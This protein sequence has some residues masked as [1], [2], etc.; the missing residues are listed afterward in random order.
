MSDNIFL[1]LMNVPILILLLVLQLITPKITRKEIYFGVRIPEE[2]LDSDKLKK[3][4]PGFISANLKVCIPY[5]LIFNVILFFKSQQAVAIF[6]AGILLYTLVNTL[7]YYYYHREVIKIKHSNHWDE[8]KKQIV[9]VDTEFSKNK[10][11]KMLASKWWFL[12][13][14]ALIALNVTM[15]FAVYNTLPDRIATH[16]N[17]AGEVNGW[18]RKSYGTIMQLPVVQ[19]F[20]VIIMYISY[21]TIGWA[22][23][24]IDTSNPEE[25]KEKNRIFRYAWSVYMI[26]STILLTIMFT[27]MNMIVLGILKIDSKLMLPIILVITGVMLAGSVYLSVKLGQGGSRINL[28]RLHEKKVNSSSKNDDE[29]WK[30]GCI[31]FNHEDPS[32]FVEK[33]FGVGWTM[34]F[35]SLGGILV[36]VGLILA[37]VLLPVLIK[38]LS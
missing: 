36:L 23:Q 11:R 17:A 3:V 34:N 30:L 27:F 25:S 18:Q 24:Q 31:Y 20:L 26:L 19:L 5:I 14:L 9:V 1:I 8:G 32:I 33:R 28:S 16:W 4:Y 10:S 15:G 12:I 22:K 38:I 37:I 21:K 29:Y 35:G 13:P 7:I 6:I 2:K